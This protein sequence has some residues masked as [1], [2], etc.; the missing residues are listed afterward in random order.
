M[1]SCCLCKRHTV[2][3]VDCWGRQVESS[4]QVF[5]LLQEK[6]SLLDCKYVYI[7]KVESTLCDH[8]TGDDQIL[9]L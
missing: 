3:C 9:T 5:E 1:T 6:S 4:P 8:L 7:M 2:F